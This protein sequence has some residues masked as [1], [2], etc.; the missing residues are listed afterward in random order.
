MNNKKLYKIAAV[1]IGL[2]TM[3]YIAGLIGDSKTAQ[4]DAYAAEHNCTWHYDYYVTEEPV[5]R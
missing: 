5:C 1:I 4:M 3:F 2:S